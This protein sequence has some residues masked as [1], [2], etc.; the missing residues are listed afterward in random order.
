MIMEVDGMK[1]GILREIK[2]NE[3][4][5]GLL[6]SGVYVLVESGYIVLVEINVGLGLFFEDVDY[7]EVG[8]E[9]V[10]E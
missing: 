4:C 10:V 1:I 6:L 2:N 3:N 5:V 7:K 9:I 8:V